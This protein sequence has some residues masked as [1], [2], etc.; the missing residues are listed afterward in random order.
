VAI[1]PY[2]VH[3]QQP[4]QPVCSGTESTGWALW[5]L[6]LILAEIAE[7]V[8]ASDG[9]IQPQDEVSS[10]NTQNGYEKGREDA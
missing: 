3:R 9:I 1:L 10:R 4:A 2:K 7:S 6:S 5:H 8:V